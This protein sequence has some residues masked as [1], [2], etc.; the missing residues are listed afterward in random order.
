MEYY[1]EKKPWWYFWLSP[2]DQARYKCFIY[3]MSFKQYPELQLQ[4]KRG[5]SRLQRMAILRIIIFFSY[6]D[7]ILFLF[8]LATFAV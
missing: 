7:F 2:Y 6:L 4:G 3:D 8:L 1:D 5:I